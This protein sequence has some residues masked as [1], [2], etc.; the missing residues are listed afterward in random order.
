MTGH[1]LAQEFILKLQPTGIQGLLLVLGGKADGT[2]LT[3]YASPIALV[4]IRG[5]FQQVEPRVHP[6]RC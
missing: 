6:F 5:K 2:E 1:E 4:T 3:I